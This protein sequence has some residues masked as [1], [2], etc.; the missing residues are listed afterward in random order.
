MKKLLLAL[1]LCLLPSVALA[2]N[3][4]CPDRPNGDNSNAC[5]NTRF[6]INNGGGGGGSNP[7]G[8]AGGSLGG[9]YPNP[10]FAS[11]LANTY[12]GNP[13]ASPAFPSAQA[14]PS[15]SAVNKGLKYIS[16][17]GF[18]CADVATLGGSLIT[19]NVPKASAGG[20]VDSGVSF[21]VKSDFYVATG[22]SDTTD[23]TASG[24]PCLTI[25]YAT[26]QA[27]KANA[28]NAIQTIH[29]AAGTYHE[30]VVVSGVAYNAG[31][32][33]QSQQLI[34]SGAGSG[35]TIWD[36][37]STSQCG[38]LTIN[39]GA[40]VSITNLTMQDTG[41]LACKSLMF[42]NLGGLGNVLQG[43]NF[44][45]ANSTHLFCEEPSS[46]I[47]VWNSISITGPMTLLNH[48]QANTGCLIEYVNSTVTFNGGLSTFTSG[49]FEA[50]DYGIIYL[51]SFG[52][53][54]TS[55]GLKYTV[56]TGLV[57]SNAW[58]CANIPGTGTSVSNQG[59]CK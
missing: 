38:V 44:G 34:Y 53:V 7:T 52:L 40:N 10:S 8:P 3:P 29:L 15:C 35:S 56:N 25:S 59:L 9:T 54:N 6:V 4:Q 24:S 30:D 41:A 47:E 1:V 39:Y 26:L 49:F 42:V 50:N 31:T 22:G 11:A 2:Q 55:A 51:N 43:V 17:T 23:C 12:I 48:A 13:S 46:V 21:N 16:G 20:L 27:L 33:G 14:L 19:G 57:N 5:A 32:N 58:G 18:G 45:V 37:G 36:S 28:G